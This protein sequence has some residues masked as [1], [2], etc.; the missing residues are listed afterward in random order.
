MT[1]FE[2]TPT[3][4]PLDLGTLDFSNSVAVI[5]CASRFILPVPNLG[6]D[7]EPLVY[8][9]SSDRAGEPIKEDRP[10]AKGLVFFNNAGKGW[11]GVPGDGTSTIVIND[12]NPDQANQ[13]FE[14][15][16][17]RSTG[18][19]SLSLDD[20]KAVLGIAADGLGLRDIYPKK[21]AHIENDLA[22]GAE[23]QEG[24]AASPGLFYGVLKVLDRIPSQAIFRETLF[25]VL[26]PSDPTHTNGFFL[27]SQKGHRWPVETQAFVSTYKYADG[28]KIASVAEF[29]SRL[30]VREG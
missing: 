23:W 22:S 4:T 25:R 9:P 13:L 15:I 16:Q 3:L 20:I 24:R 18:V 28:S 29:L 26:D 19:S 5:R 12:V 17:C 11:E 30:A 2:P 8:P 14:I 27:L 1:K 7:G 10:D 21:K 6:D